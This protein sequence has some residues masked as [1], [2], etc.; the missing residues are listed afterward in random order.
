MRGYR[1]QTSDTQTNENI[2]VKMQM[3]NTDESLF[4][5][6]ILIHPQFIYKTNNNLIYNNQ[7]NDYIINIFVIIVII[8][9]IIITYLCMYSKGVSPGQMQITTW[10]TRIRE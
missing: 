7:N 1:I 4:L 5:K 3:Q 6:L 8:R 10:G 2:N 9:I